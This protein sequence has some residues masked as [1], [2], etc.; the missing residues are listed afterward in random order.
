VY[1]KL[2]TIYAA[3]WM[4]ENPHRGGVPFRRAMP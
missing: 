1:A 3:I 2:Y 4:Q